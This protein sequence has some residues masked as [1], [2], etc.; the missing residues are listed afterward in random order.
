MEECPICKEQISY[1][2]IGSRDA[3][4]VTCPR[5]GV[6]HLT[7][8]ALVN[9]RNNHFSNREMSNIS[10]WLN[11]NSIFE[12]TSI[13]IEILEQLK[14]PSFHERA[15]KFLEHLE[16]E[17]EFA[18]QVLERTNSWLGAGWCINDK[19]LREL[20]GFLSETGRIEDS[21]TINEKR[22][23]IRPAG[24]AHLETL[25]KINSDKKQGFVAMWFADDMQQIYEN[26]ISKA[27]LDAGYLPH[28]VDQ[29]EHNDKIDDEII[30]QIRKSRFVFADFTGH[31]GGVYFEAG[32]AKGL[33]LEVFWS[34]CEDDISNLHFDIRQY[35][36]ITWNQ[37]KLDEFKSKITN[38]I[39]AVI[40][41]G[42]HQ[43]K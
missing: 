36:C 15:D 17:T 19:E 13:S 43:T 1:S 37:G 14:T 25:K 23:K 18:G 38:R 9:L 8:T 12:I 42:P 33:G 4:A 2:Q 7:R 35:N 28:R 3:Y 31:R 20:I 10:G 27:I 39:E 30:V 6:Y 16:K 34:C 24:W 41:H 26:I 22:L 29:R 32:F 40:G 21:S 11:E 5:C